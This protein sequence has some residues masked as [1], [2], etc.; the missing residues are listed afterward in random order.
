MVIYAP[1]FASR[2]YALFE[3][4]PLGVIR[5]GG[6]GG[7]GGGLVDGFPYLVGVK[8]GKN[9]LNLLLAQCL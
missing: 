1:I 6:G 7:G 3:K 8:L 9:R 5:S 4:S 2:R